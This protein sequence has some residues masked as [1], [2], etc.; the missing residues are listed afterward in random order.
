MSDYTKI[1]LRELE[2]Q[3]PKFGLGEM[4]SAR[5]ARRELGTS[6]GGLSLQSL[7][8]NK[9]QAFGHKHTTQEEMYVIV[10]GSG[11]IKIVDEILDVAA[12]DAIRVEAGAMRAFEAGP[13]GLELLAF[14]APVGEEQGAEMVQGW[15]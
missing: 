6:V 2:D 15:W 14:G 13:E 4:G 1:N 12:W 8:P 10:S 5:F 9:R 3:A 7:N 11:R